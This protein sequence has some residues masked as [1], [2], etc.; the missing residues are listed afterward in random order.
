MT[1]A[2]IYG[3][4]KRSMTFSGRTS[5]ADPPQHFMRRTQEIVIILFFTLLRKLGGSRVEVECTERIG[6]ISIMQTCLEVKISI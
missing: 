5:R 3:V 1:K 2:R 4:L 6:N